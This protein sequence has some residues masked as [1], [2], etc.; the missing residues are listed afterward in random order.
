MKVF[1]S[2]QL[3]AIGFDPKLTNEYILKIREEA[4]KF[5]NQHYDDIEIIDNYYDDCSTYINHVNGDLNKNEV[6]NL[7]LVTE[8][9]DIL[10]QLG[11]HIKHLEEAD[12]VFFCGNVCSK[13]SLVLM[14]IVKEYGLRVLNKEV[15]T[16]GFSNKID[17]NI[18]NVK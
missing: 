15:G 13:E 11:M 8:K 12:A 17:K 2:H 18:F 16:I 7:E 5:L 14:K 9:H 4:V 3:S 10:W 1:L 6:P